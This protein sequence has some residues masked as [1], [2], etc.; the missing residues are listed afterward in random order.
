M[1]I[2]KSKAEYKRSKGIHI[3]TANKREKTGRLEKL[4]VKGI[5]VWYIDLLDLAKQYISK[6]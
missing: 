2:Y 5:R 3:Q 1:E 4:T 6:L